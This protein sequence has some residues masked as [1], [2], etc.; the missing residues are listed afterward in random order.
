MFATW[1][2]SPSKTLLVACL[3]AIA[4]TAAHAFW[5]RPFWPAGL[6]FAVG[7]MAAAAVT[8]VRRPVLRLVLIT[9]ALFVSAF[10]R[11]D[12]AVAAPPSYFEPPARTMPFV[13]TAAEVSSGSTYLTVREVEADGEPL[14]FAVTVIG[15]LPADFLPGDRVA[16]V[17]RPRPAAPEESGNDLLLIRGVG[18][19][20]DVGEVTVVEPGRASLS[21]LLAAARLRVR[22]SV[23]AILPAT[24]ASLLLGL[25]TGERS[26]LPP[27][28]AQAFRDTGTAHVLAVSGY[29]IS[30]VI[31]FVLVALACLALPLRRALPAAAA[32]V[33][34]FT[35]F[36]GAGP[37]VVRAALMGAL[38]LGAR[39]LGRRYDAPLGLA[40]A[41]A[42]MLL[43]NPLLL[44]HDV[45]FRLSF[46]AV[47]GLAAVSRPIAA[48]LKFLRW[49]WL[50]DGL[51]AT[52]AAVIFT[53]PITLYD[54]GVLA[55]I[56]PLANLA[57]APL[58]PA[59]MLAGIAAMVGATFLPPLAPVLGL[60]PWLP[61]KLL[62]AAVTA[63]A[64]VPP[65]PLQISF[66]DLVI[67]YILLVALAWRIQPKR[68][69]AFPDAPL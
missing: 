58:V 16:W 8:N 57:V 68:E 4:G 15:P 7:V 40:L 42:A 21:R 32:L 41:A 46:A 45:G 20:C 56:S 27:K 51:G 35:W 18:W 24:E 11:Y 36:V 30:Q 14:P 38:A 23:S 44:R 60:L 50:I 12:L 26:G 67:L 6:G 52:L 54:F 48:A 59:A 19:R 61:L 43:A 29:N 2:A 28:L 37:S 47:I 62:V 13:G 66:L 53:L 55:L 5:E 25:L 10:Y 39:R 34:A 22:E 1:P 63:A 3:A 64:V 9:A 65:L 69:E 17:C 31:A 49:K 33:F